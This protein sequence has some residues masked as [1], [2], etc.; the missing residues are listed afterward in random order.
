MKIHNSKLDDIID[1]ID[2]AVSPLEAVYPKKKEN[3]ITGFVISLLIGLSLAFILEYLDN[4][5]KSEEEVRKILETPILGLIPQYNSDSSRRW[6]KSKMN[7]NGFT[8]EALENPMSS[9]SEA[10]RLLGVN[11]NFADLDKGLK[12]IVVTSPLPGD[13]K[14]TI[15]SNLAIILAAREEKVLIIDTDFRIPAIHKIFQFY[16]FLGVT[17][18]LSKGTDYKL[19]LHKKKGADNLDI[20]TSGPIPP[21]PSEILGSRRMNDFIEELSAD[22]DRIIFD[23]PPVFGATDALVLA[24]M[25]D[26]VLMVFRAGKIDKKVVKRTKEVFNT[27]NL[28]ILGGILNGIDTKDER[29]GYGYYNNYYG[30]EEKRTSAD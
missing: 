14:T 21:N 26:G 12:T 16:N 22:Y 2:T 20:L 15:A 7:P 19:A 29:F 24:S 11:V 23:S 8:L 10:F 18:I 30:K 25:L 9:T 5:V 28:K 27:A 17:N 6:S 13:G 3:V 4:T 1:I